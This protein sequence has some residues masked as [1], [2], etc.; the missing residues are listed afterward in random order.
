[1]LDLTRIPFE[2]KVEIDKWAFLSMKRTGYDPST[3]L[4]WLQVQNKNSL[5]FGLQLRGRNISREEHSLKNFLVKEGN[6]GNNTYEG[7]RN[8]SPS[9]Y[10]LIKEIKDKD[11]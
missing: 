11:S 5:E 7:D 1:M 4:L 2:A 8:T 6:E 9:Y 10:K 3:Y